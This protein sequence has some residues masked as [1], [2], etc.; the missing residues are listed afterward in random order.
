MNYQHS[1]RLAKSVIAFCVGLFCFIVGLNNILDFNTNLQFVKHVLSMDAMQN[2][3]DGSAIRGRAIVDETVHIFAYWMIIL[4]EL[5]AGIVCLA[6]AI[7]MALNL[8]SDK[9]DNGKGLYL[10]GATLAL[11]IWY[12]GFAVIGAE[13]FAM[14]ASK[15]NGQNSAYLFSIFILMS[16]C[17]VHSKD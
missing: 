16:M 9:F 12:L 7:K 13:W 10:L 11:L 15:W 14:W 2:W 6:G 4:F 1:A 5:L 17:F 8:T 3:F